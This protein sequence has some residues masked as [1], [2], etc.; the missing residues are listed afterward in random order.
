MWLGTFDTTEAAAAAYDDACVHIRGPGVALNL[1]SCRCVA[2]VPPRP[3]PRKKAML[4]PL[5]L[6]AAEEE[7]TITTTAAAAGEGEHPARG[8][9]QRGGHRL[10]EVVARRWFV[11]HAACLAHLLRC[12]DEEEK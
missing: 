6:P 2:P 12:E 11:S 9:R 5:P 1:P 3:P 10:D 8:G 7:A 4:F